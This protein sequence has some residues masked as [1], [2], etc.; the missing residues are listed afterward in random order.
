MAIAALTGW[1]SEQKHVVAASFLGWSLDAFDFF[2]LVFVLKDI[3]TEF[4]TEISNV[5][6]AILL[7]LIA[8]D[9]LLTFIVPSGLARVVIDLLDTLGLAQV[10]VLGYSFGGGL[11]QELAHRAPFAYALVS[12]DGKIECDELAV[13]DQLR[14]RAARSR[15]LL[16]PV[17]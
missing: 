7:G 5:T 12:E 6:L 13:H 3:T 14:H 2:L 10:D 11:A 15:R 8:T 4:H 9:F 1:T 17:A 16:Q